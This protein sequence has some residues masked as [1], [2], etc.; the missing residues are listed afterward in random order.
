M[1]DLTPE[2]WSKLP[3]DIIFSIV[4]CLDTPDLIKWSCVSRNFFPYASARVWRTLR[5]KACNIET[6]RLLQAS[7]TESDKE[8]LRHTIVHFLIHNAHR[9]DTSLVFQG[10]RNLD[11]PMH[12]YRPN[13]EWPDQK[14]VRLSKMPAKLPGSLVRHLDI[15][16]REAPWQME[17]NSGDVLSQFFIRLDGLRT[18][19]YDGRLNSS[20]LAKITEVK[21]LT[22]LS[23]RIGSEQSSLSAS[24]N[25]DR[26]PWTTVRLD[27]GVLET[28]PHLR[29]LRIGHLTNGEAE[30]L[31]RS[32]MSLQLERLQLSTTGWLIWHG[33][34]PRVS[35]QLRM[36]SPLVAFLKALS[37]LPIVDE[38]QPRGF[39]LTL[40]SLVLRDRYYP[41]LPSLH[42]RLLSLITHC[43]VL[44]DIKL[45]LLVSG[46][47]TRRDGFDSLNI[48]SHDIVVGVQSWDQLFQNGKVPITYN[49]WCPTFSGEGGKSFEVS[50]LPKGDPELIANIARVLD[51]IITQH[52][53]AELTDR[54]RN[55]RYLRTMRFSKEPHRNCKNFRDGVVELH[56]VQASLVSSG[57]LS[58]EEYLQHIGFR[59][60]PM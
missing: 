46:R 8:A 17:S 2:I 3:Y 6:Y 19:S 15:S 49:Y 39:P 57:K 60:G 29:T 48:P 36:V 58:V 26:G 35:R 5:I 27:L 41:R 30:G 31:A 14:F 55:G 32:V 21:T 33:D 38:Q 54:H 56:W 10:L 42:Q 53:E 44:D 37:T 7:E 28:L 40:S 52:L 22:A 45:E 1:S 34:R 43:K 13:A 4:D 25:L 50:R 59:K 24:L 12:M 47:D 51:E 20:T 16:D 23:L 11:T 18:L 9:R